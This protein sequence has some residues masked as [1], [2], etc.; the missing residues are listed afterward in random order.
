MASPFFMNGDHPCNAIRPYY[1]Y[2]WRRELVHKTGLGKVRLWM[3]DR[4]E[5]VL[6][7]ESHI[8]KKTKRPFRPHR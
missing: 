5:L 1:C 7:K 4:G 2:V 8:G 3:F 6:L